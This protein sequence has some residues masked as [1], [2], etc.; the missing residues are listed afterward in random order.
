[1]CFLAMSNLL[2]NIYPP[3]L[4]SEK[5][6]SRLDQDMLGSTFCASLLRGGFVLIPPLSLIYIG[7]ENEYPNQHNHDLRVGLYDGTRANM[8]YILDKQ[9]YSGYPPCYPITDNVDSTRVSGNVPNTFKI[10][11][12]PKE[13]YGYCETAQEGGYLSSGVFNELVSMGKNTKILVQRRTPPE[14]YYIR[15]L[16]IGVIGGH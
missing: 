7:I 15:Y 14:N 10:V 1:M 5:R 11:V 4:I 16:M 3:L 6:S 13:K 12:I 8:F 9:D 2:L